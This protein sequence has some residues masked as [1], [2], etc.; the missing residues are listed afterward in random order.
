LVISGKADEIDSDLS[1]EQK[2]VEK[3][4]PERFSVEKFVYYER[5]SK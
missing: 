3:N 5:V 1:T 2:K 4:R